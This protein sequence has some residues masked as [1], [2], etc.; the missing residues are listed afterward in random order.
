MWATLAKVVGEAKMTE[1]A[2][3]KAQSKAPMSEELGKA[4]E[5]VPSLCSALG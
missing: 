5:R 1:T 2:Q 3:V 4:Q